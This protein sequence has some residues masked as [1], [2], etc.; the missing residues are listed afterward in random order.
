LV[1]TGTTKWQGINEN[2]KVVN[3]P[4]EAYNR[5]KHYGNTPTSTD[6]RIIGGESVDHDP[7][8]VKRYYEGNPN[9]GEKP[10]YLQTADERKMSARDRARM[11]PS[12]KEEQNRQGAQMTKY[13]K[14]MKRKYG[15]K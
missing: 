14:E 7:P 6:R 3:K 12:T 11:N 10:G 2:A 8:L 15:L 1:L 4:I 5:K 13:A 9:V